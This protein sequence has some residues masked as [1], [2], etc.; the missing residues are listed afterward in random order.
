MGIQ[1][2]M[3]KCRIFGHAWDEV[4]IGAVTDDYYPITGYRIVVALK[5]MRCGTARID[6]WNR[7]GGLGARKYLYEDG[8]KELNS[9]LREDASGDDSSWTTAKKRYIKARKAALMAGM[10]GG[11]GDGEMGASA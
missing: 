1:D 4:P 9:S 11:D 8:Y 3:L 5:C 2:G 7:W 6:A 10:D